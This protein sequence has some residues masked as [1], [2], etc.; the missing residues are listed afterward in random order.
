M[1]SAIQL[2]GA[3]KYYGEVLGIA[4]ITLA[5]HGGIVGL[6]GPNGAGKST[7]M[8]LVAG[9]LR[10]SRGEATIFGASA[11]ED[12][13]AR[14]RVGYCP[15]HEGTYEELTGL[16]LVSVLAELA[17]LSR[18]DAARRAREELVG[19]GL[20]DAMRRRV[21]GYSKGM[22]Q[23]AK[24]AQALAHDP[25]V[26][27]LD[28]PLTGCDPLARGRIVE[29]IRAL[30]A[31]GKTILISSHVLHEIEALTRQIVLI[32]RGQVLAEGDVYRLRELIDEHPHRIRVECDR[33]REL[34]R[35]LIDKPHVS[36]IELRG[37]SVEL[38]TAAPDSLYDEIPLA[39]RELGVTIASL[40]SPDNNLGA[41]FEYLTRRRS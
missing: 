5:I 21:G 13:G 31:A 24:L 35:A 19:L 1:I 27:L 6:L 15:E 26:L 4:D 39:A 14:R 7:L 34:A 2:R 23:R 29:R 40:T 12:L 18:R 41:V 37:D 8:K 11:W 16:E 36:R 25:D 20:E 30:G 32:Y 3:S 17:G 28:E 38:E 33:P 10:P 22:R 9:L